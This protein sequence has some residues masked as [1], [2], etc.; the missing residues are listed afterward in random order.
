MEEYGNVV[1]VQGHAA[2]PGEDS[3]GITLGKSPLLGVG[4]HPSSPLSHVPLCWGED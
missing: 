2:Q 3:A 1:L 4:S